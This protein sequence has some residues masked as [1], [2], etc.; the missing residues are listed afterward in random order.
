MSLPFFS[1]QMG[2]EFDVVMEAGHPSQCEG[3]PLAVDHDADC[4]LVVRN[5]RGEVGWAL[6]S[7]LV[8]I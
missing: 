4:L 3:L 1:L 6:A 8:P 5:A 7:F 2:D